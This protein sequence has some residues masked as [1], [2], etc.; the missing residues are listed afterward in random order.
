MVNPARFLRPPLLST[1]FLWFLCTIHRR[2]GAPVIHQHIHPHSIYIYIYVFTYSIFIYVKIFATQA[3]LQVL[4]LS[5]IVTWKAAATKCCKKAGA[6]AVRQSAMLSRAQGIPAQHFQSTYAG[7]YGPIGWCRLAGAVG[8]KN[9][10]MSC[11]CAI[12]ISSGSVLQRV[13]TCFL[14]LVR[15][16]RCWVQIQRVDRSLW[17]SL[18]LG[19]PPPFWLMCSNWIET[20]T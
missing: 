11:D 12:C 4:S 16:F 8:K 5:H 10:W 19:S 20:T 13:F 9:P 6:E 18:H 3:M 17:R 15:G 2:Y 14:L 1:N 7:S